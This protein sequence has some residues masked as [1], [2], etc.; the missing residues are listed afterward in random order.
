MLNVSIFI[1]F[2]SETIVTGFNICVEFVSE[3]VVTGLFYHNTFIVY[4]FCHISTNI[5]KSF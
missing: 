2:F 3:T 5:L 1:E 4:S